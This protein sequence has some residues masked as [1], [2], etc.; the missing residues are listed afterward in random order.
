MNIPT[1]RGKKIDSDEYVEG[2]EDIYNE[3]VQSGYETM[4]CLSLDRKDRFKEYSIGNIDV[5]TWQVNF[6]RYMKYRL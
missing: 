2:F 4:K 3:W 6:D 1:Y 5:S